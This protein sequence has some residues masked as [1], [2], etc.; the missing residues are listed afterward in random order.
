MDK[1]LTNDEF[2]Y[3]EH[4]GRGLKFYRILWEQVLDSSTWG[5]NWI[6][7]YFGFTSG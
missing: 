6:N 2:E 5:Q 7:I 3:V 4:I 1:Y